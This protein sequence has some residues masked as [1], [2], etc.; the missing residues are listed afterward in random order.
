[1]ANHK[2]AIKRIRQDAKKRLRNRSYKSRLKSEV[3]KLVATDSKQEAELQFR[4]VE[5]LLD[6]LANKRII[7]PNAAA[8]RKSKLARSIANLS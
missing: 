8:N 6:K 5:S 7:H 4:K 2:S 1:M 3:K